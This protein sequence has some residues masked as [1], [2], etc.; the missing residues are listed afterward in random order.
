MAERYMNSMWAPIK[1]LAQKGIFMY[2]VDG[3][4]T[5]GTSGTGVGILGKGSLLF[6][7]TNGLIYQNTGTKASPTWTLLSV[8]NI[9]AGTLTRA[10]L[11]TALQ[12][13]ADGLGF[14][15]VARFTF[16]PSA[17]ATMRTVAA[18]GLGVTLPINAVICGGFYRVITTFAS[19]ADSATI[20]LHAQAANDI[21]TAV[22]ISDGANPWDAGLQPI[23]PKANT[24]ESTGIIC[25]AAREIT[26]T[27]AVQALTAGKL[28]GVVYYVV[29]G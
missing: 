13:S 10:M 22:A 12:G 28:I 16:D 11:T 15:S 7:Y 21:R 6:D 5:S 17:D 3:A 8:A 18:H 20:A 14:L 4:P 9:A 25:T 26:A 29:L 19:A 27:V 23:T 2:P 24:P 1:S